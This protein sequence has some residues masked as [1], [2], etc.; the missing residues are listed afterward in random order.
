MQVSR[1]TEETAVRRNGLYPSV[2]PELAELMGT[3]WA[4]TEL[5]HLHPL[6]QAPYAAKRRVALSARFPGER[7]VVP[8]GNPKVRS[9]DSHYP[10]RPSS[11]YVHLTGDQTRDGALVLEPREGGGHDAHVHLLPRSP[12]PYRGRG[13]GMDGG[14]RLMRQPDRMS[15]SRP[16]WLEPVG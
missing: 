11:E 13:R 8:A 3:G 9:N 10:F 6:E 5:Y 15:W 2:S 12:A 16:L 4:D 14:P 1:D 7:L